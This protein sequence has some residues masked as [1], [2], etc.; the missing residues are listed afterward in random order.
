[1]SL[2]AVLPRVQR[3]V[4]NLTKQLNEE[5]K[6]AFP[7]NVLEVAIA[8]IQKLFDDLI[9]AQN[10]LNRLVAEQLAEES[11]H[12]TMLL[13]HLEHVRAGGVVNQGFKQIEAANNQAPVKIEASVIALGLIPLQP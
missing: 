10:R 8:P 9:K 5:I 2:R 7:E 6:K 13:D 1:M 12:Y 4:E 3:D 11:N